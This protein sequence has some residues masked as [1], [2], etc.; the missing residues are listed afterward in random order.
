[1][2]TPRRKLLRKDG[3]RTRLS[4]GN[5][6]IVE[7]R[8]NFDE[9]DDEEILRG[10]KRAEDGSWRGR[11]PS[12]VPAV[13]HQQVVKRNVTAAQAILTESVER[14]AE[15]LKEL[16]DGADVKDETKLRAATLVLER[17]MGKQPDVVAVTVADK[18]Y[19]V[20]MGELMDDT[21]DIMDA[22]SWEVDDGE[23]QEVGLEQDP[24]TAA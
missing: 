8:V 24:Q 18:P 1:M 12:I 7:G 19:Q 17:I 22:D 3:K 4:R 14:A 15:V 21:S 20:L 11:P 2:P 5:T 6:D 16:M 13:V 10:R 9:W 23:E